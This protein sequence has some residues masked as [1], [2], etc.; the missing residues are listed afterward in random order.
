MLKTEMLKEGCCSIMPDFVYLIVTTWGQAFLLLLKKKILNYLI[1][2][3]LPPL[4]VHLQQP[5][6]NQ[7]ERIKFR[8]KMFF[9]VLKIIKVL[10]YE[11]YQVRSDFR[12]LFPSFTYI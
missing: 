2:T 5:K 8:K 1:D 9:F 6:I 11:M 12:I 3:T 7:K 10:H 4:T